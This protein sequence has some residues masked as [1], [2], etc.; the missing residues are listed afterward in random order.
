VR[1]RA[2]RFQTTSN[3]IDETVGSG[4]RVRGGKGQPPFIVLFTFSF[5]YVSSFVLSQRAV[6]LGYQDVTNV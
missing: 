5:V 4:S 3:N 1:S 2:G 6:R